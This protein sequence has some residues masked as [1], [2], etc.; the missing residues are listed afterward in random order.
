V[1]RVALV[2]LVV[3]LALLVM[4]ISGAPGGVTGLMVK[5]WCM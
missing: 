3:G 5:G 1:T 2:M 4:V